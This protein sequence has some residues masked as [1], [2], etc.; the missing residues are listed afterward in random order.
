MKKI[1]ILIIAAFIML[2]CGKYSL[3]PNY[4]FAENGNALIYGS[5]YITGN[6]AHNG[7]MIFYTKNG[8]YAAS[9]SAV[10]FMHNYDFI[11]DARG[12]LFTISLPPGEYEIRNFESIF[13]ITNTNYIKTKPMTKKRL[14]FKVT[15]NNPTYIGSYTINGDAGDEG[16]RLKATLKINNDMS[17]DKKY[18]HQS[19]PNIGTTKSISQIPNVKV[20]E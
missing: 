14:S 11:K 1:S 13:Q 4:K 12:S 20:W 19:F 18:L 10:D 6:R 8:E 15:K 17:H 5:L 7:K 3:K 16:K 2:G 9:A